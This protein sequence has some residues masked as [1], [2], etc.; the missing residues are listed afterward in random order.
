MFLVWGGEICGERSPSCRDANYPGERVCH[1]QTRGCRQRWCQG[2]G[3]GGR[4]FG[5]EKDPGTRKIYAAVREHS[6]TR[7][8]YKCTMLICGLCFWWFHGDSMVIQ[9]WD[10]YRVVTACGLTASDQCR[11]LE[12]VLNQRRHFSSILKLSHFSAWAMGSW[13]HNCW[14]FDHTDTIFQQKNCRTIEERNHRTFTL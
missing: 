7:W 4:C 3:R 2:G 5:E 1:D 10:S 8:L 12:I 6:F 14:N 11:F 13:W 9:W